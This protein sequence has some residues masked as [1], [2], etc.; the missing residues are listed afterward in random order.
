MTAKPELT[1]ADG[2]AE[3]PLPE[4]PVLTAHDDDN[5]RPQA[6]IPPTRKSAL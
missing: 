4:S 1:A 6:R 5:P 3:Q 2:S